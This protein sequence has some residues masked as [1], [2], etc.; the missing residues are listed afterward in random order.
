MR[1]FVRCVNIEVYC[2]SVK[3]FFR[4][5]DRLASSQNGALCLDGGRDAKFFGKV[6][7]EKNRTTCLDSNRM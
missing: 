1:W 4:I 6:I 3:H 7:K 2:K 5:R